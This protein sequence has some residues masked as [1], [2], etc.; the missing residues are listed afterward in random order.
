AGAG[1]A[2]AA[3]TGT[4]SFSPNTVSAGSGMS[5]AINGLTGSGLPSSVDLMLQPGFAASANS[6]SVLCTAA[7]ASSSTC[8]ASSQI[9]TGSVGVSLFSSPT[10]VPLKI[11]LGAPTQ[12]GDIASVILSGAV[13]GTT[14]TVSG[15]LFVPAGGG[16]EFLLTGFPAVPVSL[17]A[18]SMSVQSSQTISKTTTKTVTR[19]V[20]R[21]KGKHRKKHKV[22]RK[23]KTTT[24]TVY[25]LISNPSTCAGMWTGTA[26]FT[27][28][29]GPSVTALSAPCTP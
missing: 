1:T 20:Y 11:F 29:T 16:L 28:S 14:L 27:Y 12:S 8:P 18:L 25:S 15:R 23:I 5:V 13:F 7:Q 6:V 21:G 19:Y 26:T 9:G 17:D 22:K 2:Q 3:G 10:T 24:R 4:L